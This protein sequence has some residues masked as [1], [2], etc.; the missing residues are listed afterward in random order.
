MFRSRFRRKSLGFTLIE[1]LGVT[2]LM[3]GLHSRGDYRYAV[4]RANE[5]KGIH[6]LRQI[7]LLLRVQCMTKKLPKA[8]FH[9]KGDPK[10]D[11]KSILRLLRG[12]PA[13]LF[14]SPFAPE[15]LKKKGL[16]FAWND[17]VNGKRLDRLPKKTWLLVDLAAFIADPKVPKPKRYLVLYADGRAV[18]VDAPPADI[19]KAVKAAQKK[20]GAQQGAQCEPTP[21]PAP[22]PGPSPAPAPKPEPAPT[23]PPS[24]APE[25]APAPKPDPK[26]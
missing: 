16:T 19:V 9:P 6:N 3:A 25:P 5:V 23:P 8:A 12:A 1:V 4:N 10:K 22:G 18:A 11:P 15:A 13:Q 2:A 17:T 14:I 21:G 7:H 26:P 24:P 20:A